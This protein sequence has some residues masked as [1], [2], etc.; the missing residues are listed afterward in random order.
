M[1][2]TGWVQVG[3]DATTLEEA[4]KLADEL[5]SSGLR[6]TRAQV[7][8]AALAKGVQAIKKDP[9]ILVPRPKK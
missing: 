6:L 5:S 3:A 7:L 2:I 1:T 8:R 9:S 4:E